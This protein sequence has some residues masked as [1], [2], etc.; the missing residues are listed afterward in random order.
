MPTKILNLLIPLNNFA[1][2]ANL[3]KT[4]ISKTEIRMFIIW[5][6][7]EGTLWSV[8]IIPLLSG[9]VNITGAAAFAEPES[10]WLRRRR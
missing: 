10:S 9:A 6:P 8:E 3:E 5:I 2:E 1:A 7:S 4:V